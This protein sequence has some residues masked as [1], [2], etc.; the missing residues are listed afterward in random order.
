MDGT[1]LPE[2]SGLLAIAKLTDTESQVLELEFAFKQQLLDT[3]GFTE[4]IYNLWG[5]LIPSEVQ[6]AFEATP[7]LAGLEHT[8][9]EIRAG[10]NI[11]CLIT[12]SQDIYANYFR[13]SGFDLIFATKYPCAGENLRLPGRV[14]TPIDKPRIAAKVTENNNIS[15]SSCVAFGDSLSD[16]PLFEQVGFAVSVN[17]D[18]H[19]QK[20]AHTHYIGTSI[21]EAYCA[22]VER[23]GVE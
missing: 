14:L 18:H 13:S 12:M 9:N 4:A 3:I 22:A 17:G 19:I 6:K 2:T 7:K 23:I 16:A 5:E 11:S 1:L 21:Y 15:L 10:G 20:L 8:L